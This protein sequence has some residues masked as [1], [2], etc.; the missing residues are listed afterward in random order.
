[1]CHFLLHYK[2]DPDI[3]STLQGQTALHLA[4]GMRWKRVVQVLVTAGANVEIEDKA[5]IKP[6]DLGE[7]AKQ[8]LEKAPSPDPP[9]S[10][11]V[12]AKTLTPAFPLS[13]SHETFKI[14]FPRSTSTFCQLLSSPVSRDEED[15]VIF[16]RLDT[17][18]LSTR[19]Q[20]AT[21]TL[22]ESPLVSDDYK[23]SALYLWLC[24]VRLDSLFELLTDNGYDH[25]D[26]LL[27]Q[28]SL[29]H[30]SLPLLHSLGIDKVG[31]RVRLL[32]C[33]EEQI[34]V[35]SSQSLPFP[36][37]NS[38]FCCTK[39]EN[40]TFPSFLHW[41]EDL[42]LRHLHPNFQATGYDD[43]SHLLALMHTKYAVTDEVLE[44][45]IGIKKLGYRH[46]ILLKLREDAG[47]SRSM[48]GKR[49]DVERSRNR[50]VWESCEVM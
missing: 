47:V 3:Q 16:E 17:S 11:D 25:L 1:M 26:A 15:I 21:K 49:T 6:E 40:S 24:S 20:E 12:E 27:L 10:L 45:D 32:A 43:L 13:P 14:S 48:L 30:L 9:L 44:R 18:P 8:W 22:P 38:L 5:G 46:R 37:S 50:K 33:L 23:K 2:A 31:E 42:K 34:A 41:L 39:V 29:K 28:V 36:S 35:R 4:V 19:D 7:E